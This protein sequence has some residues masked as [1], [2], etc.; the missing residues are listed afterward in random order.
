MNIAGAN[1]IDIPKFI[2]ARVNLSF[3]EEN[4]HLPLKIERTYWIYIVSVVG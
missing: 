2:D 3:T 1:I 4:K